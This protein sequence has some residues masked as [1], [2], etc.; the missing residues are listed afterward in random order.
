MRD[1]AAFVLAGGKSSRMGRD[2]AA[3]VLGGKTLLERA[4]AM[5]R[6]VSGDVCVVGS[7]ISLT[8][9][10]ALLRAPVIQDKFAGQGPLAG[11][12]A[13]L[14]SSHARALNFILAIDMP[15]VTAHLISFL[16][17]RSAATGALVTAPQSGGKLH[18]MCAVYRR[19]FAAYARNA[20]AQGRN[21][22]E[23]AIDRAALKVIEENELLRNGFDPEQLANLNTPAEFAAA[24]ARFSK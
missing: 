21:K 5:A 7:G 2:K 12:H 24:E 6:V 19:E 8:Q 11:I 20:L 9:A 23:N 16:I 14:E 3:L 22:I 15:F 1:V 17:E 10:A 4:V 18:P 13:A